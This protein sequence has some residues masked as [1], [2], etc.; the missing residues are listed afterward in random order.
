MIKRI[1]LMERKKAPQTNEMQTLASALV[2]R[3]AFARALGMK[4]YGG[5]RDVSQALGYPKDFR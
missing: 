5:A 2:A 4:S 1:D 3:H